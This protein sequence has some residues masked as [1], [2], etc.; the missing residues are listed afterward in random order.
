MSARVTWIGLDELRASL[1]SLPAD[2]VD[3]AT[4]LVADTAED[5]A[6]EIRAAYPAR[7]G[8]LRASV[9]VVT[10]EGKTGAVSRAVRSEAPYARFYESGWVAHGSRRHIPGKHVVVPVLMRRRRQLVES[11]I[12]VVEQAGLDVRR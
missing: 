11:L 8:R 12:G 6:A 1:Q 4:P 2:L 5:A 3:A 9:R 10:I 7:T